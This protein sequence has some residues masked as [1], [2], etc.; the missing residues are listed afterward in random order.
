MATVDFEGLH[1]AGVFSASIPAGYAGF[2][3]TNCG[4]V[5]FKYLDANFN[6]DGYH[7]V[8]NN[9]ICGIA[10]D[11]GSGFVNSTI[12]AASVGHEQTFS[13]KSGVFAA[14]FN[15]DET[16]TFQSFAGGNFVGQKVVVL[17]QTAVT[18][19]FGAKFKHIDTVVILSDGGTDANPADGGTGADI[20]MDDLRVTFDAMAI[21]PDQGPGEPDPS[22]YRFALMHAYDGLGAL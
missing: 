21:A 4:S 14:A 2:N 18:I 17:D 1:P 10:L 3:W 22:A 8:I 9:K 5:G 7:N 6:A 12:A 19:N 15:Q 11:P 16:V 13:L 20:A